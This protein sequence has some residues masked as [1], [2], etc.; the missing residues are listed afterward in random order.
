M[1]KRI[2]ELEKILEKNCGTYENNCSKCPNQKECDE[3][4]KLLR[5]NEIVNK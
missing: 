5:I 1:D 2:I 3:Y 4:C